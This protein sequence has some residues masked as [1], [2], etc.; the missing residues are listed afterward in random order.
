MAPLRAA[1][2]PTAAP[3]RIAAPRSVL[4]VAAADG[5]EPSAMQLHSD[6][7]EPDSTGMLTLCAG[8]DGATLRAHA[9]LLAFH[10]PVLREMMPADGGAL[11]LP[12]KDKDELELLV[13]WLYHCES[14]TEVRRVRQH[15]PDAC[16]GC[17]RCMCEACT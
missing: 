13:T 8:A 1:L 11:I 15:R 9:V 4:C 3:R 16:G 6:S 5:S 10:S 2:I 17:L 12:D 7:K 14:I